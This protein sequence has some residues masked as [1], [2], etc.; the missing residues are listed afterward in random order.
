[1][2]VNIG[3]VI[4]SLVATA[5]VISSS[6]AQTATQES[7]ISNSSNHTFNRNEG[8]VEEITSMCAAAFLIGLFIAT[9]CYINRKE[10]NQEEQVDLDNIP[11]MYDE[12]DPVARS[13]DYDGYNETPDGSRPLTPEGFP[14]E[15]QERLVENNSLDI[16][17]NDET[18]LGVPR[19]SVSAAGGYATTLITIEGCSTFL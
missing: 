14:P 13:P 4:S 18:S 19:R 3:N 1:M 5:S 11:P 7:D 8:K 2:T 12:Q 15:Y 17:V 16:I 10:C 9:I 6:Y